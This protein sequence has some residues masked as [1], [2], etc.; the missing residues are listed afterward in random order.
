MT[1]EEKEMMDDGVRE[2]DENIERKAAV[3]C[4]LLFFACIVAL[5]LAIVVIEIVKSIIN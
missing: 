3:T 4:F 5:G 2:P 1:R